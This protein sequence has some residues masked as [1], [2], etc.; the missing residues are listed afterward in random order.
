MGGG[1]GYRLRLKG[2]Q[3][4]FSAPVSRLLAECLGN[5]FS[6]PSFSIFFW[7]NG[8]FSECLGPE[9]LRVRKGHKLCPWA[10]LCRDNIALPCLVDKNL[11]FLGMSDNHDL[12]NNSDG[13][14]SVSNTWM[15]NRRKCIIQYNC[16]IYVMSYIVN[17]YLCYMCVIYLLNSGH[18]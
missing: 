4:V 15:D 3:V 7:N 13:N 11:W 17:T 5:H 12:F 14:N 10:D 1:I 2:R 8:T 6:S 18:K 16:I 9:F